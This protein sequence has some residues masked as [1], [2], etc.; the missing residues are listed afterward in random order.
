MRTRD[1]GSRALHPVAIILDIGLPDHSGLAVLELL[2]RDASVRHIP[3][4][5]VSVHDYQQVARRMG[6]V[7][8]ALK[9]VRREELVAAFRALEQQLARAARAVLV[10]EDDA[11][12]ARAIAQ[13]LESEKVHIICA[14][15]AE[16]ALGFV[17]AQVFDCM[18]LDLMLPGTSGFDLLERLA[19]QR[20]PA[21]PPVIVYTARALTLEEEQRL[22]RHAKSIVIKGARSPDRLLEEVTLFLHQMERE[23]PDDKRQL[24]RTALG[25]EAAFLGR[26]ILV[27]EDDV[28]NVFVLSSA[29]EPK[30]AIVEIARNG[31]EALQRVQAEPPL[32]L[33]LM[34]IM[35]PEMDGLTATREIRRLPRAAQLPIIALTA[36]AMPDDREQCLVAGANDYIAKPVDIKKLLSLARIWMVR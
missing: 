11:L 2:K 13:L 7:G 34:D 10:V 22:R 4:H 27:V 17:E 20:L 9:P 31:R 29:L 14:A 33:V 30:G 26:R 16:E 21:V 5:V 35:M 19:L 8:Y 28:R 36:K 25:R 23:L 24:L 6:V 1:C 18:V 32:D 12:Q 15:T 3:V